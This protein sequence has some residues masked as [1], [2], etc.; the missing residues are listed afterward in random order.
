MLERCERRRAGAAVVA[1]DQHDIGVCLGD[2]R[3]HR[4]DADFCDQLHV[5]PRR[6]V[7]VLQVV[8][9]LFQVFDRVDV[10]MRWR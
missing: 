6:R 9:E 7:G 5:H 3:S 8:D 10:V 4:A 2:S 1:G